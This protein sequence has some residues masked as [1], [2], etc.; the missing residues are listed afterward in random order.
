MFDFQQYDEILKELKGFDFKTEAKFK[1]YKRLMLEGVKSGKYD[2]PI[3]EVKKDGSVI[4]I[5][6]LARLLTAKV[7]GIDP[8]VELLMED[9]SNVSIENYRL[10]ST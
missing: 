6:G 10:V 5:D 7:L 2:R 4:C 8:V 3:I 1:E 9:G